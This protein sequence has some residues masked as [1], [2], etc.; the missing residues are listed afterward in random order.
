[1]AAGAGAFGGPE[2]RAAAS[3]LIKDA[4][5]NP[6]A[7][8]T[9]GAFVEEATNA[10]ARGGVSIQSILENASGDRLV[11]HTVVSKAGEVIDSHFR[12]FFKP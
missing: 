11:Q 5:E 12:P 2:D 6:S 1:M 3:L 8:H 7:W 4:T 9:V 10:K